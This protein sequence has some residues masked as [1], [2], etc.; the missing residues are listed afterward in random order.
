MRLPRKEGALR[1]AKSLENVVF[2][3][4]FRLGADDGI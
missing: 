4:L 2:S 3:R 1:K